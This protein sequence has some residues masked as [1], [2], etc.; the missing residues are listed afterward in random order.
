MAKD[1]MLISDQSVS[2]FEQWIAKEKIPLVRGY[3]VED[4]LSLPLSTWER[5]GCLATFIILR[6]GEGW[7][8]AWLC[9][10]PKGATTKPTRHL[11]EEQIYVLEGEGATKIWQENVGQSVLL[12]WRAHSLFSPPLTTWHQHINRGSSP[13]RLLAVTNL[14]L[15]MNLYCNPD[16]IY[17]LGFAFVDRFAGSPE[18]FTSKITDSSEEDVE[19][20][21]I[22]DVF[23]IELV[24]QLYRGT[25]YSRLGFRLCN[26]VLVGHIGFID[27]GTHKKAHRH[28]PGA[29][30]LILSGRGY[31]LM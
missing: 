25:G 5:K 3:A 23:K 29:H 27:V 11:Y 2:P 17:N 15:V 7:N 16:F 24:T 20:N 26:N 21:F 13:V 12:E 10:V 30:I 1:R 6:G 22:P 31:T 8:C 9:E 4:V 19:T 28:Y 14:P 18:G